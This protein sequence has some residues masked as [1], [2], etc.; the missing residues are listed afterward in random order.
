MAF[1]KLDVNRD[2]TIDVN[3]MRDRF[4][5]TKCPTAGGKSPY[6][7][8]RA[9]LCNFDAGEKDGR[10]TR[11]EFRSYYDGV[12]ASI[13]DDGLFEL[14]LRNA[15]R[16][17]GGAGQAANTANLR[18]LV[19]RADGTQGIE[20]VKDDLGISLRSRGAETEVNK[21]TKQANA[22]KHT[23]KQTNNQTSK[24]ANEQ[25]KKLYINK[26]TNKNKQ[27]TILKSPLN[28]QKQTK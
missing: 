7:V 3:D 25:A 21:K 14:T 27:H 9:F 22:K 20:T 23:S 6:D 4:D 17:A 15:W 1:D 2:D 16:I 19:T 28:Q 13:D 5:A 10:V 12:S 24:Q 11:K 18:V 26:Q 8:F